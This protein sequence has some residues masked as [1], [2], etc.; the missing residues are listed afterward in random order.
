MRKNGSKLNT[1]E[2]RFSLEAIDAR[3]VSLVGEFNNY[4]A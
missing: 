4:N 2:I 3:K 1:K